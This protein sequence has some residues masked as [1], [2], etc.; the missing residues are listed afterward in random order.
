MAVTRIGPIGI[1]ARS[2]VAEDISIAIVRAPILDLHMV[3]KNAGDWGKLT[4]H[5]DVT[6]ITAEV[7]VL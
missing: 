7:K 6:H 4:N 2:H 5:S 1:H 3:A